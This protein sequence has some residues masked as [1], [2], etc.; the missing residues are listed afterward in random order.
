M[1]HLFGFY[2]IVSLDPPWFYEGSGT[3]DGAAAKHYDLMSQE[4][5]CAMPI[6]SLFR[7]YDHGAAFVWATGPKLHL[8]IDAIRAWGTRA[9]S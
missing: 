8:A 3:K 4:D 7:D 5:I 1:S 9:T 2:D 6:R